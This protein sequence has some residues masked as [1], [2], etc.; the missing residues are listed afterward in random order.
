MEIVYRIFI[1]MISSKIASMIVGIGL[2]CRRDTHRPSLS[3]NWREHPTK[4][5]A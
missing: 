5:P 1:G 3:A 2:Q 4:E